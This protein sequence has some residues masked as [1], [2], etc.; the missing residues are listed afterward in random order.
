M[1]ISYDR[2][3]PAL[4]HHHPRCN[5]LIDVFSKCNCDYLNSVDPRI[6][7]KQTDY[8][9]NFK[10]TIDW[11]IKSLVEGVDYSKDE[12]EAL[13]AKNKTDWIAFNNNLFDLVRNRR[14]IRFTGIS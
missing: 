8:N 7:S 4:K 3:E 13:P 6:E 11:K 12:L 5:Y 1:N 14:K 9:N 2:L 10:E